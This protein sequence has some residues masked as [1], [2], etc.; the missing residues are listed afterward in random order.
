[1]VRVPSPAAGVPSA[2]DMD[3]DRRKRQRGERDGSTNNTAAGVRFFF[4]LTYIFTLCLA[5][6]I[7]LLIILRYRGALIAAV[8]FSLIRAWS[9]FSLLL[10]VHVR[11]IRFVV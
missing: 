1:M 7:F 8:F 5:F 3:E 10:L 6:F 4:S 11:S 9:V 2:V